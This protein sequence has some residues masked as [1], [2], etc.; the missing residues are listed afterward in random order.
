MNGAIG[1]IS[2]IP[3]GHMAAQPI[4][5]SPLSVTVDIDC[6]NLVIPF[7]TQPL[8]E[9][10]SMR[11]RLLLREETSIRAYRETPENTL[12]VC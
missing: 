6:Q 4:H 3:S 9:K 7:F 12:N 10:R 2:D 1:I 8:L 5:I 11:I